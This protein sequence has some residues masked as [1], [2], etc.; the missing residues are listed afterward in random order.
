MNFSTEWENI[1]QLNHHNSVWPWTDII[2]LVMNFTKDLDSKS[3]I[4]E[5]GCGAGANVMFFESL[6]VKYYGIDGSQTIVSSL[7]E[8]FKDSKNE[9]YCCDFTKTLHFDGPFDLIIDRGGL[10]HNSDNNIRKALK[11]CFDALKVG[12]KIISVD[13]FSD[14]H[15]GRKSGVSVEDEYTQT[16]IKEGSLAKTGHVHFS[17]EQNIRDLYNAWNIN[18]LQHKHVKQHHPETAYDMAF[19]NLVATKP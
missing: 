11:L 19:W 18:F 7:K 8:R 9:F 14:N 3:K 12:G 1:Y 10:T 5:I 17:D 4:L 6:D 13:M 2:S 15:Y 16:N